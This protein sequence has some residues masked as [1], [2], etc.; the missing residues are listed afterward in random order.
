M[1]ECLE[2]YTYTDPHLGVARM[3]KNLLDHFNGLWTFLYEEG[4]EPTNNHAE[5]CLR[6][7]VIWRKKYFGTHSQYGTEYVGRSA[8]W[9]TT[10]RLQSKSAF[11]YLTQ[12]VKN[13]FCHI[14][15]PPLIEK[16]AISSA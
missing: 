1:G 2:Q 6:P 5:Q 10:C 11:E 8:S 12:A 15:A 9:I 13:H 3:A 7:W 16:L 4:V 14:P